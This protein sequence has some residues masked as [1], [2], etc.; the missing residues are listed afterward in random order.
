MNKSYELI[1]GVWY[2]G[3]SAATILVLMQ[4]SEEMGTDTW[5]MI[6][7]A[8]L[9]IFCSLCMVYLATNKTA[10]GNI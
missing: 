6:V 2:G 8:L 5:M 9:F 3:V 10:E 4:T 7:G 1:Y